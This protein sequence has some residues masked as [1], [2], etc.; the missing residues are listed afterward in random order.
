[1]LC[2]PTEGNVSCMAGRAASLPE[3][4][5]RSLC[6]SISCDCVLIPLVWLP[7]SPSKKKEAAGL[8]SCTILEEELEG[9]LSE[10]VT[11]QRR[12]MRMVLIFCLLLCIF[13]SFI[14]SPL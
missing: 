2:H 1:M 9:A 12:Q 5:N 7:F 13:I 6:N 14:S 11:Y 10:Q 3:M 4:N 8:M